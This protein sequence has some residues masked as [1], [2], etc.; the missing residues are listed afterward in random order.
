V[1]LSAFHTREH[2]VRAALEATAFQT[3]EVLEAMTL[4]A[5]THISMLK[6]D[7]GMT[8]ND[9]LMQL[10]ADL[11]HS[12]PLAV[13]VISETTALGSAFAAGLAV[14]FWTNLDEL[15]NSWKCSKEWSAKMSSLERDVQV[16]LFLSYY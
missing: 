14:K 4:D 13:P 15:K 12:S 6:V 2:I 9:L 1:G 3:T 16:F 11:L 7:G 5:D 10:Q 8:A